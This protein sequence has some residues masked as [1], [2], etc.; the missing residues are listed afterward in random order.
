MG[1]PEAAP[2]SLECPQLPVWVWD[3]LGDWRHFVEEQ[4][5]EK[6]GREKPI[7]ATE[8]VLQI[9]LRL[10][11]GE[12]L[13]RG[14]TLES[15]GTGSHFGVPWQRPSLTTSLWS[16]ASLPVVEFPWQPKVLRSPVQGEGSFLP[17]WWG[18]SSAE[19]QQWGVGAH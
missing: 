17:F 5:R 12:P 13:A 15:G 3:T 4:G 16:S 11:A 6:W 8:K 9:N 18:G 1:D 19:Y 2:R 10:K 7:A 14:H